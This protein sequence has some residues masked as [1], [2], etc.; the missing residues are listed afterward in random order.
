MTLM[1][2]AG[3]APGRSL[4]GPRGPSP[5]LDAAGSVVPSVD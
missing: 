1:D 3:R 4:A 5:W 2:S